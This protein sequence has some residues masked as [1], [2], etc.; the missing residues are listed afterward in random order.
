[1]SSLHYS[2]KCKRSGGKHR[3]LEICKFLEG[4]PEVLIVKSMHRKMQFKRATINVCTP[5]DV[6]CRHVRG[7]IDAR[8][9]G[10]ARG[11]RPG[12]TGSAVTSFCCDFSSNRAPS[13]GCGAPRSVRRRPAQSHWRLLMSPL[14]DPRRNYSLSL[15]R[16]LMRHAVRCE[17]PAQ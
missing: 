17:I 3:P 4:A 15:H 5:V 10:G 12:G 1:M 7:R 2:K 8:R 6:L 13:R 9:R 11:S 14:Q 16:R